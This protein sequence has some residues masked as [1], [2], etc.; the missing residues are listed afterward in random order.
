[1]KTR[2]TIWRGA[3]SL[4]LVL[5]LLLPLAPA[6]VMD[7]AAVTQADIDKLK[8]ESASLAS[9]RKEIQSKLASVR[10]EKGELTNQ[11]AL[12]EDDIDLIQQE[13]ASIQSRISGIQS[14]ITSLGKQI[15]GYTQQI[16][17]KQ[18]ELDETEAEE[19][20]LYELFCQRV[21]ELEEGG[22]GSYWSILFS[23]D[24][25]SDLLDNF[26]MVEEFIEYDNSLM[27][28]LLAIQEEIEAEKAELEDAKFAQESAKA[29]QEEAKAEL[30]TQEDEV[31]KLIT[32]ISAKEDE[33]EAAEADLQKA[34]AAVD[35]EIKKKEA[36][37]APKISSVVSEG[38]FAWPMPG[39][40]NL[41]SLF[42]GRIH[43]VTHRPSSH[44]GID[45]PAPMGTPIR[46]AKSGVV[47]T[48]VYGTGGSWSYGNYVV[49]SHSD[50]TSTLY[51][52]MSSRAVKV[53]QTVSQGTVLGCVGTTGRSTGNH[54]HF[55]VRINGS[56]T[57][58]ANYFSGL[59]Y[60][61]NGK[62]VKLN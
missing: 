9:Q 13:I 6:A 24:D 23:S 5:A 16:G 32:E 15:D 39:Y 61:S 11:K 1:M 12:L 58:P 17:E 34:A 36:E 51:A 49:V 42:G 50:G 60:R 31:Q 26:M 30:K 18:T 54:L 4:V 41:S 7:T 8:Q 40:R 10:A 46:C 29:E 25:F 53:G 35:A 57:D 2:K 45:I 3:L 52:H 21:R 38:S 56:R 62:T 37:L 47:T 33:L 44:T 27:D 48:S 55:E 28:E 43:P 14:Q 59:Y 20:E 22:E 19:D